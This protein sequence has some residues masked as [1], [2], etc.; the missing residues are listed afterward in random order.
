MYSTC[1]VLY[2]HSTIWAILCT[3]R[4]ALE[5]E[6][7]IESVCIWVADRTNLQTKGE[8]VAAIY[9]ELSSQGSM[10]STIYEWTTFCSNSIVEMFSKTKS[11]KL[12]S[13]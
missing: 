10:Y 11:L 1:F 6:E 7:M 4:A 12:N 9:F 8:Q 13:S 5:R 2:G 3:Q